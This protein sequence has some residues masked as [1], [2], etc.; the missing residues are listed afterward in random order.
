[1]QSTYGNPI[2]TDPRMKFDDLAWERSDNIAHSW[3][4]SLYNENIIREVGRVIIKYRGGQPDELFSPR[5]GSFNL[6]FRMKF[7]DG[8]SGIV[9]FPIPGVSMFAEEKVKRE[10]AVM[11]FI[12]RHTSIR[13]PRVFYCGVAEES[14]A[15]LGP[16]IVME[17]IESDSDLVDALNTPGLGDDER[18][19]LD[20]NIDENRLR[21]VYSDMGDILLQL[22]RRTFTEVGSITNQENDEWTATHRP[23]TINMNE[24]VQLGDFPPHLLPQTTYKTASSYFIALAEMHMTHLSTQRNDT[25][26]T[27]EDCRRKYIARCLFRKLARE[28][29]LCSNDCGPFKLFCDDFRPANVLA[30]SECGFKA[31]GAIDWEFTYAAPAEFVYSPPSW[32][33]LERPEYWKDGIEKWTEEY[34]KRLPVFLEETR[35]KEDELIERGILTDEDR[36]SRHMLESWTSGDFWVCYAARRSWAFDMLYWAK[37]DRRFFGDGDIEDRFK[38]LTDEERDRLD[39]FV[40]RKLVEKKARILID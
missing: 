20:P 11:R 9:R 28:N 16:F 7:I 13:I 39:E 6:M 14:P 1:M 38:L 29:R 4:D 19:I 18:S 22:S 40:R 32:L 8:G 5:K 31:V 24:L 33:L 17:Y 30:N 27:A 21:S 34:E 25:I 26:E 36:L 15:G 23:L 37:I 2:A 12:E 3:R 10:V 35:K